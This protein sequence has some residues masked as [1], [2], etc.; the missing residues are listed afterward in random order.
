MEMSEAVD[1]EL[2]LRYPHSSYECKIIA[3]FQAFQ[4]PKSMHVHWRDVVV[5]SFFEDRVKKD[6]FVI[7]I[8]NFKTL[9]LNFIQVLQCTPSIAQRHSLQT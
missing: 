6:M 4:I 3:I 2:Q 8:P 7:I 9:S 5:W 1:N